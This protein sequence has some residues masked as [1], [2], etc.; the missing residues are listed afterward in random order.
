MQ[1]Q[2]PSWILAGLKTPKL[3]KSKL[4]SI[5]RLF[6]SLVMILHGYLDSIPFA[7]FY[8]SSLSLHFLDRLSV[9]IARI[10][11]DLLFLL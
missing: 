3:R 2:D 11:F 1:D 4:T 8:P 6:F 9:R 7:T 5:S 10:G